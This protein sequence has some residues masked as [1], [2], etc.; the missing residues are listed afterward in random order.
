MTDHT[1]KLLWLRI[2]LTGI[3]VVLIVFILMILITLVY[4]VILGFKARGTPD[5]ELINQF[6]ENLSQWLSPLLIILLSYFGGTLVS[7]KAG[8]LQLLHGVL[9]GLVIALLS[10]IETKIFGGMMTL[11]EG[12]YLLFYVFAA[13]LGGY[14]AIPRKRDDSSF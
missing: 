3:A 10:F 14:K 8:T 12:M 9:L 7:R 4:G 2:L 5:T 13:G 11:K 6:A 1:F